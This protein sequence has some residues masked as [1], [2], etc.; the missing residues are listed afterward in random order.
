MRF[1]P[2]SDWERWLHERHLFVPAALLVAALSLIIVLLAYELTAPEFYLNQ[3]R[4]S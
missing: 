3:R 4:G 1:P 2:G